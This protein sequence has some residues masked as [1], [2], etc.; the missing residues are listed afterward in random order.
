MRPGCHA[1]LFSFQTSSSRRIK[2][3]RS[4]REGATESLSPLIEHFRLTTPATLNAFEL[5]RHCGGG[6]CKVLGLMFTNP[7]G[8]VTPT[9]LTNT[10]EVVC[11]RYTEDN[12]IFTNR[13]NVTTSNRSMSV[14]LRDG[15]A[16]AWWPW[17]EPSIPEEPLPL[18]FNFTVHLGEEAGREWL[19]GAMAWESDLL[20][21]EEGKQL[22]RCLRAGS[23]ESSQNGH[24][25]AIWIT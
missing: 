7:V 17:M 18:T 4:K 22:L 10:F 21:T 25:R 1:N 23:N 14:L 13:R 8:A 11:V 16:L 5:D 15:S 19:E 24:R 20:A 12:L 9:L 3:L 6:S 2:R